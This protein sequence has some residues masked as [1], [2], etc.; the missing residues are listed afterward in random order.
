MK[1]IMSIKARQHL[2]EQNQTT[3]SDFQ[4][5]RQPSSQKRSTQE[6]QRDWD[7]QYRNESPRN[8]S[9]YES[10]TIVYHS[11]YSLIKVFTLKSP[12]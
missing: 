4:D 10:R 9:Q 1:E 12:K 6:R 7:S 2:Q 11:Y 3:R 8:R 5:W